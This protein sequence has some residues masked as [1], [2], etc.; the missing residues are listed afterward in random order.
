MKIVELEL[1]QFAEL[2]DKAKERARDWWRRYDDF[3]DDST[4]SDAKAI[5]ALIGIGACEI[6]Y[7]G[8]ASQGDGASFTGIYNYKPDALQT[9]IAYAPQDTKL[10]AIVSDI[11]A[12]GQETQIA[13]IRDNNCRYSHEYTMTI[14]DGPNAM[15]DALRAFARWIYRQLESAYDYQNSNEYID[16]VLAINEYWFDVAGNRNTLG[17]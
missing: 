15:L 12:A 6:Q 14:S 5:A 1:Y 17:D 4:L 7:S 13:I 16:D 2:S 8:F 9:V 3:D 11:V 10:H